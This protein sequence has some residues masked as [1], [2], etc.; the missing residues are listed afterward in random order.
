M[1][2]GQKLPTTGA[3]RRPHSGSVQVELLAH[4]RDRLPTLAHWLREE[5]PDWYGS[6]GPGDPEAD[7]LAFAAGEG[8]P[9]GV[10]ALIDGEPCGMAALKAGSIPSHRHLRPWAAAGYVL[11]RLRGQG[12]GALLLTALAEQARTLGFDRVYCA[13]GTSVSLLRRLGWTQREVVE[14][15]GETL[16][17]FEQAV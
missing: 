3:G 8:L 4:H 6:G 17:I 12:I 13:T 1:N 9:V 5:W 7:L 15:A 11:P 14:H 16:V 2:A 10:V